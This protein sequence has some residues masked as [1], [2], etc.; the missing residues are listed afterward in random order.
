M[1]GRRGQIPAASPKN[2][3]DDGAQWWLPKFAGDRTRADAAMR[4]LQRVLTRHELRRRVCLFNAHMYED[5]ETMGLGPYQYAV[6]DLGTARLRM[7]LV[8]A[9]TDA[10]V[11]QVSRSKPKPRALTSDGD[12]TLKQRAKG[13]TRWWEGKAQ[14][15]DLYRQVST[16]CTRDSAVFG[17]GLAKVERRWPAIKR[18]TDVGVR[19]ILPWEMVA[20]DAEAQQPSRLRTLAHVGYYDRAELA[21]LYPDSR[22]HIMRYAPRTGPV[23]SSFDLAINTVS[24]LVC[25][26]EIWRLPTYPGATD[27]LHWVGV[28]GKTFLEERW[29]RMRFPIARL[30]RSD[31]TLGLWGVSI[32]HELRGRQTFINTTLQDIE[33]CIK[34]YGHPRVIAAAGSMESSQ[35][36]DDVDSITEYTG[37]R[38]PVVY[39]PQ[40]MPVEVYQQIAYQWQSGFEQIG[41]NQQSAQSQLPEGLSGSG[42]SIRAWDD[43][44]GGR[45][46]EASSNAEAWHLDIASL[47]IDEAREVAKVRPDYES[48]YRGKTYVEVVRFR[49]VDPGR[50][51]F[52]LT[53]FP[54]SRLSKAPAQ[55]LAQ[56][57]ELFNAKII[58]PEEFREL[59][60]FPDL[61]GEDSLQNAPREL[62][63][64][65][66]TRF[67]DAKNPDSPDVFVAPEPD[68][69]VLQLSQ[70]MQYAKVRAQ[71]DN[72][73]EANVR[74]LQEFID[75]CKA[76][77]DRQN[78]PP[79]ANANGAPAPAAAPGAPPPQL[80]GVPPGPLNVPAA[81]PATLAA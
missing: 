10:Y 46:Y 8:R 59:L 36:D 64:K 16:P 9:V 32:P 15:L 22:E 65:L 54:E 71:L 17:L 51:K 76:I 29:D 30:Y 26:S 44:Q 43:V 81:P 79:A 63:E 1:A 4:W 11:S 78:A 3:R 62:C 77:I 41:L 66:V 33:D 69:P 5:I 28:E 25:V 57:Q 48:A 80:P 47:M 12:W 53:V 38:P 70:R 18:I 72:A 74:L 40:V 20:D 75:L 37:E 73:P 60:E 27:G 21:E 35:W 39:T 19:R 50:D 34:I 24:D 2:G 13:L 67:L 56:L 52:W 45:L 61:E 68:W 7:N 58:G 14:E 23:V 6:Y 49:D 42:A 31:A 55:R